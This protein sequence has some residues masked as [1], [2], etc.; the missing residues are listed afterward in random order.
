MVTGLKN[1]TY[2]ERLKI[3]GL[4][5]LHYRRDRADVI[6]LFKIMNDY[7]KVS[8][9]NINVADNICRGGTRKR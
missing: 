1:K 8:L 6:Q 2:E 3:L 7:D 5:T 4:P 9:E